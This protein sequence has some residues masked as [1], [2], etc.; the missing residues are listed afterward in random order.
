MLR[1]VRNMGAVAFLFFL[2][3]GCSFAQDTDSLQSLRASAVNV[4]IDG[5][6]CSESDDNACCDYDYIRTN[7]TFVNFVRDRKQA[8]LHILFT[9][10]PTGGNGIEFTMNFIGRNGLAG[11][12]DTIKFVTTEADT[13]DQ[14]RTEMVRLLKLGL[15]RYAAKTPLGEYLSVKYSEPVAPAPVVDKWKHWVFRLSS[16]I[17]LQGEKNQDDF[18]INGRIRADH[19]SEDWKINLSLNFTYDEYNYDDGIYTV[20]SISRSRA[21]NSQFIRSLT[22][23][24]SAG[25]A[26]SSYASTY[27]NKDFS[28]YIA[29]ALEYNIF[30][31]SESTRRELRFTY[32]VGYQYADYT[33][34]TI[35]FKHHEYLG[36]HSLTTTLG[37]KQPWGSL[38]TSVYG[39]N[40][41][42]DINRYQ[43]QLSTDLSLKITEGLSYD[44][45]ASVSKI[46]NQLSL[47]AEDATHEEIL[48]KQRQLAT[49][50]DYWISIGLTYSFGSIY[51]N[52]VNSRFGD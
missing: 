21:Y 48:L 40:F 47:P 17:F 31:Y 7:I 24:W 6:D 20:T 42:H 28:T 38:S 4:F 10:E 37:L 46:N 32:R 50:Y 9:T 27:S 13:E 44:I 34:M 30:P 8:D 39:T 25:F 29:G 49:S 43:L 41:F 22:D 19:V 23:H 3:S 18:Y 35:Y 52:I 2:V 5:E 36:Y 33:A 51:S 12:C 14:I 26:H 1:I 15:A 11:L 16:S 45:Y